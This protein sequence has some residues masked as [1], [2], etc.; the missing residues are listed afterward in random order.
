MH[1]MNFPDTN[2]PTEPYALPETAFSISV[3][4]DTVT[5]RYA[6]DGSAYDTIHV[7]A[8]SNR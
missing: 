1:A 5:V 7:T 6:A 4:V 8:A 2:S 3:T